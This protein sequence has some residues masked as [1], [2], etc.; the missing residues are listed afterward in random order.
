MTFCAYKCERMRKTKAYLVCGEAGQRMGEKY[1]DNM[2]ES[3]KWLERQDKKLFKSTREKN[4]GRAKKKSVYSTYM[5]NNKETNA[6]TNKPLVET[7]YF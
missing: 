7:A 4:A 1:C 2:A 6:Q 3:K 5:N